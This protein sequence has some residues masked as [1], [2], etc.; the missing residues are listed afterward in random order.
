MLKPIFYENNELLIHPFRPDDLERYEQLVADLFS[1]LT[2]D[3]TL[4]Y[5]PEKRLNSLEEAEIFLQTMVVN[6]HSGRNYVHFITDKK[7]DKVV[8]IINLISPEVAKE[9][10]VISKYPHF[11]EFYLSSNATGCYIMTQILPPIVDEILAQ[12]IPSIGAVVNRKNTAAKRVLEKANF[13]RKGEF[14]MLQ[15]FYETKL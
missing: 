12:G 10:Y 13:A 15:D 3:Q 8:G 1:I 5:I 4:K 7:Q 2:D 11:I 6:Y 14:D 9:F